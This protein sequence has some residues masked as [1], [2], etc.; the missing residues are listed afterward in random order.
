MNHR[1]KNL[2]FPKEHGAWALTFEPLVLAL[3]LTPSL[4]GLILFL[5]ATLAFFAH[6]SARLLFSREKDSGPV[7]TIFLTFAIPAAVLL[8]LFILNTSWPEYLPLLLALAL[9]AS[10]LIL[11]LLS[12]ERALAAEIMASI[13][14]GLIALSIVVSAHWSWTLGFALLAIIYTRSIGTTLYIFYR[15]RLLK[16]QSVILW[17][18]ILLHVLMGLLLLFLLYKH[19][20]PA[21][22]FVAG[23]ILIARAFWNLSRPNQ[24]TTV[25]KLGF[26]EVYYGISYLILTIVGYW[27]HL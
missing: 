25:R 18:G 6:P 15:V 5:G 24:K 17:P 21:L 27:F 8:A 26:E 12:M 13:S 19:L 1:I 14:I 4:Q 7:L 11:E 10:Y 9:M 16:K 23:I 3:V 20:I 2:I 22:G